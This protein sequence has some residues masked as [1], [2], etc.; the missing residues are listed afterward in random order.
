MKESHINQNRQTNIYNKMSNRD[1]CYGGKQP[2]ESLPEQGVR[3]MGILTRVV[4]YEKKISTGQER[5]LVAFDVFLPFAV[6]AAD[7]FPQAQ[8]HLG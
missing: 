5:L 7:T 4:L 6:T 3:G 8:I 2:G 1:K